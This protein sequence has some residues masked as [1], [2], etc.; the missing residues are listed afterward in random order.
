MTLR[1]RFAL[2]STALLAAVL[3]IATAVLVRLDEADGDRRLEQRARDLA[4]PRPLPPPDASPDDLRLPAEPDGQRVALFVYETGPG[5]GRLRARGTTGTALPGDLVPE[6]VGP[7]VA[8]AAQARDD[9]PAPPETVDV[10]LAGARWTAA[11]GAWPPPPEGRPPPPDREGGGRPPRFVAVALVDRGPESARRAAFLLRGLLVDAGALALGGAC[12]YLLARRMLRPVA[13]AAG[14]AERLSSATERLP[15]G[16]TR[17]ELG[18]LIGVLNGM[19]ARL[20]DAAERER[21]FQAGASH[22]L[23]R[24]L[25]ALLGELELAAAAGR[26]ESAL[27]AAVGL[28]L[29]DARAMNLLL[30]DLIHHARA[31]SGR[32]AL[33][34]QDTDLVE[35]VASAVERSR[36]ATGGSAT[37]EVGEVPPV[38]LRV[39]PDAM[40]RVV[41]NLVVN[42]TVH[43]GPAVRARVGA[44]VDAHHVR[45]HVDDDGPG[46]PPE[47]AARIFEPFA[48]GDRARAVRGMGLGLAIA[49]AIVRAHG[50][51]L[52]VTSPRPD[53]P[54]GA[55]PGA[56][57]TVELPASLRATDV[58]G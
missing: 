30:D 45:L 6:G 23:R 47:E 21:R 4:R 8:R 49:Q 39:D 57:F 36:R 41:E 43:G 15:A 32:L 51:R 10:D 14:A 26:S 29:E 48:R 40:R 52:T 2:L 11:V 12:A 18:R 13:V 37:V 20:E 56:R 17:D 27:R 42:A 19:L 25:A 31:Q 53:R 7:L 3:G 9:P 28:A 34:V 5:T 33:E 50:G 1:A 58:G 38:V 24:P 22:E 44:E 55:A 16:E 54:A 35:I 46:V